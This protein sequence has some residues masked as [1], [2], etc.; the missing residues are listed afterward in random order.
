MAKDTDSWSGAINRTPAS[1]GKMSEG[2]I[3]G[4]GRGGECVNK[5][6]PYGPDPKREGERP[7]GRAS[8][9]EENY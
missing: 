6:N 3:K 1:T 4:G 2:D 7:G 5:P 9:S 8:S